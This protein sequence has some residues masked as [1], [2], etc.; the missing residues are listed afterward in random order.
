MRNVKVLWGIIGCLL[1][2]VLI[3]L[4][5][6]IQAKKPVPI[7][8]PEP[9]RVIENPDERIV[10]RIGDRAFTY[11]EFKSRLERKY[12]A[13]VLNQLLDQEALKLEATALG[14]SVDT[15]EIEQDL[16]RMQAGYESKEQFYK[17]ME[18][19]LGLNETDLRE[20]S[21]YKLLGE[22]LA[23]RPIK[24]S[25]AEIDRYIANHPE[26]FRSYVQFRVLKIVVQT[27]V[28]AQSIIEELTRGADF[29]DLAKERSIDELTGSV[30]GDMGWVE[31]D[32]PFVDPM[33]LS[34]VKALKPGEISRPIA[35][36]N[37]FAIIRLEQTKE[38][39]RQ[40]DE[41]KRELIRRELALMQAP[42][43]RDFIK[44]LREKR[45]A[46]ILDEQLK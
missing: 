7:V 36:E 45:K 32:D 31:S 15:Q 40:V 41:A 5:T 35:L 24:I 10:A 11:G 27:R 17:T 2:C 21:Y 44:S 22:K 18:E 8:E 33:I 16:E 43:I 23:I 6:L 19:Q 46:E 29:E 28:E 9:V 42:P 13:E 34:V 12:G 39:H 37:G 26:E 38:V 14:I 20:D 30:G 25:N 3:L 1:V 4:T